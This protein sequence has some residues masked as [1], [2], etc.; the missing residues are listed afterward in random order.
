MRLYPLFSSA[1]HKVTSRPSFHGT[2]PIVRHEFR[3][4]LWCCPIFLAQIQICQ[5]LHSGSELRIVEFWKKLWKNKTQ[6]VLLIFREEKLQNVSSSELG[7][8]SAKSNQWKA[9][10]TLGIWHFLLENASVIVPVV[11]LGVHHEHLKWLLLQF[12]WLYQLQTKRV[13]EGSAYTVRFL[14]GI[15]RWLSNEA[16]WALLTQGIFTRLNQPW[17]LSGLCLLLRY[18][19]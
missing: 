4:P 1:A 15:H 14:E 12:R 5:I 13:M 16:H 11:A 10:I 8:F 18:L 17:V 3:G 6:L 2:V 9:S 19:L 7:L